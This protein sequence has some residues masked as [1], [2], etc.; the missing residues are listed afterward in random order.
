MVLSMA[1]E[2]ACGKAERGTAA[3]GLTIPTTAGHR[4]GQAAFLCLT[5]LTPWSGPLVVEAAEVGMKKFHTCTAYSIGCEI[6]WAL[7][8]LVGATS[9]SGPVPLERVT[10]TCSR[11][12]DLYVANLA[13]DAEPSDL[14]ELEREA[15]SRLE[16]ECPDHDHDIELGGASPNG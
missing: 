15:E 16:N 10:I 9:A 14:E 1:V 8:G 13:P 11:C 6:V 4:S 5:V 2:G 3:Q 7:M 12:G